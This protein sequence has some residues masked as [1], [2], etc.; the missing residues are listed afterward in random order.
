METITLTDILDE[1]RRQ[2]ITVTVEELP[3]DTDRI[4]LTP[5]SAKGGCQCSL[6]VSVPKETV[7]TVEPVGERHNCCGKTFIVVDLEFVPDATIPLSDL[8]QQLMRKLNEPPHHH[9]EMNGHVPGNGQPLAAVAYTASPIVNS[10]PPP[11]VSSPPY[12]IQPQPTPCGGPPMDQRLYQPQPMYGPSQMPCGQPCGQPA[13]FDPRMV[14]G[15]GR[16]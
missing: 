9:G 6:A 10:A 11:P 3:E 7:A 5:W 16:Y 12:F 13:Q 15:N 4:K 2:A 1:Q 14:G 8:F